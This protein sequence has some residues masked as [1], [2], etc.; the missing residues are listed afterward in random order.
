LNIL[1]NVKVRCSHWLHQQRRVPAQPQPWPSEPEE[2]HDRDI[3]CDGHGRRRPARCGTRWSASCSFACKS[4][5]CTSPGT[6]EHAP[7]RQHYCHTTSQPLLD[8]RLGLDTRQVDVAVIRAPPRIPP[9]PLI[10]ARR[11]RAASS[12]QYHPRG[13]PVGDKPGHGAPR[14]PHAAARDGGGRR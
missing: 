10:P 2:A 1:S 11:H 13:L 12:H 8:R 4:T 14:P 7:A 6:L 5:P 3:K 9:T